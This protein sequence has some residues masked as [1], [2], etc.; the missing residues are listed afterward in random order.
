MV[1]DVGKY[2]AAKHDC[3]VELGVY[4]GKPTVSICHNCGEYVGNWKPTELRPCITLSLY[5]EAGML[6]ASALEVA[7]LACDLHAVSPAELVA[8]M[9][10]LRTEL[11]K[12]R[13]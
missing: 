8:T 6:P 5:K 4:A 13:S 9:Y 12:A 11:R 3:G 2:S 1:I 10:R 7:E